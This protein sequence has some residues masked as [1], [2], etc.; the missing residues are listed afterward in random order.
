[1]STSYVTREELQ[2]ESRII[3]LEE[4]AANIE[5]SR[6]VDDRRQWQHLTIVVSALIAIIVLLVNTNIDIGELKADFAFLKADVNV[7]KTDVAGLK[8]DVAGLKTDVAFLKENAVL[9]SDTA[10]IKQQVYEV[11]DETGLLR[12]VE[13][14]P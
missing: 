11:L 3:R 13:S 4:I 9:K 10:F 12:L 6:K 8:T 7:L 1:M 5:K 2:T 14:A